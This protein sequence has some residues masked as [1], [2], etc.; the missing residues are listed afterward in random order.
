MLNYQ[1]QPASPVSTDG[2]TVRAV[3]RSPH[4]G[5]RTYPPIDR[6]HQHTSHD[7]PSGKE[8]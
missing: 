1:G 8:Q 7:L 2:P 5:A 3:D 4:L 6:G